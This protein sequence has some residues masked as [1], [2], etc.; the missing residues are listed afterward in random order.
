MTRA[1]FDPIETVRKEI[2]AWDTPF[3]ELDCY[4]TDN[5]EQIVQMIDEL[6]QSHFGSGIRGYYFYRSSVGSTH[7]VTLQDGRELFIKVRLPPDVNA[8]LSLDRKSL[9]LICAVMTWLADRSFPC[10]KPIL[11]PTPVGRSLATVDEFLDC[12]HRGNGF[13]PE[14]RKAI[15]SSLAQLIELLRAFPGDVSRLKHFRRGRLLYPQPHSKLFNFE[16][17]AHGAEW[18]DAFARRAREAEAAQGKRLLGHADWRVEHLRFEAGSIVASYDW[19]SLAFRPETELVGASVFGFTADWTIE[20]VRRIPRADDIR[21]YIADYEA[22]RGRS[23]SNRERQSLF[24][25]CVYSIAYGARCT[26]SLEPNKAEWEEDTWPYLLQTDG[27]LLL[28][29]AAR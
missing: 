24:A 20:G 21:S 12:G 15:A 19:D 2:A 13:E 26:H 17:T 4:G 8:D 18:I 29:E 7:A 3:V 23:F 28:R 5:A 25:Y 27:D 9:E 6:C 14:C 10:P 16:K 1:I 22:A 11:G